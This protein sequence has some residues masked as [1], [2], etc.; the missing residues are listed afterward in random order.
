MKMGKGKWLYE[1]PIDD[2]ETPSPWREVFYKVSLPGN[3]PTELARLDREYKCLAL[4]EIIRREWNSQ[5]KVHNFRGELREWIDAYGLF[6]HCTFILVEKV[7]SAY[8]RFE[9]PAFWFA[10]VLFEREIS[11]FLLAGNWTKTTALQEFRR[12]NGKLNIPDNP[13]N[14]EGAENPFEK[15]CT[16]ALIDQAFKLANSSDHF[17]RKTYLPWL[18]SRMA[19][20]TITNRY[21]QVML[22]QAGE[23][24]ATQ[25]RQGRKK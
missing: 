5:F 9:H 8:P 23:S 22:Q 16:K 15:E 24:M 4:A 20:A 6:W 7:F 10:G 21:G 13:D 1:L 14:P 18:R 2:S 11:G 17:R 12:K 19:L 3:C 25:Q